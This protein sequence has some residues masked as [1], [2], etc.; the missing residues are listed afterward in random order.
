MR[1]LNLFTALIMIF[2]L[3]SCAPAEEMPLTEYPN[4]HL[5]IEADELFSKL[6]TENVFLIDAR[7]ETGDS[8]LPG[9]IHFAAI[10]ELVDPDHPVENYL[11]GPDLFQE[12]MREIGLHNNHSVVIYDD[13]NNL[14]AARLFYALDYYGFQNASLLNG[15]LQAWINEGFPLSR[16]RLFYI[17]GTFEVDEQEALMCDFDYIIE[18]ANSPDKI[19]FDARSA[20]E[21]IGEEV[22][23]ERGG[24]IPNAVNIEWRKVLQEEGIP[25]FLPPEE[26]RKLF[27]ENGITPEKE[28]IPHCQSNVRGSHA[29]FTLRLMGY[30]SVRPYEGSWFEY[31]NR[32]D[33]VIQ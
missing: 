4:S 1:P 20:E 19:I 23:S 29:Y 27:A 17:R 21:Y 9:A 12:K 33:A 11:I 25:Y 31:G 32:Q 10:Q 14:A 2:L 15:G 30:D 24:H 16:E 13:G 5:L 18:A 28:I 7:E 22:R 8:L 6:Q 26:L 3:N